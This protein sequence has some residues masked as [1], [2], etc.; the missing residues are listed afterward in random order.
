M[1][2]QKQPTLKSLGL[3]K[4]RGQLFRTANED[5]LVQQLS[6]VVTAL[7]IQVSGRESLVYIGSC[8]LS[9]ASG[10]WCTLTISPNGTNESSSKRI[11]ELCGSLSTQHLSFFLINI[12]FSAMFRWVGWQC[13]PKLNKCFLREW[14]NEWVKRISMTSMF[15][16]HFWAVFSKIKKKYCSLS[17]WSVYL[18]FF[19]GKGNTKL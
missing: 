13:N 1:E 17:I 16:E 15:T 5:E 12:M 4:N 7:K 6:G 3:E 8:S 9:D 2:E 14:M 10:V 18:P 19:K 11:V